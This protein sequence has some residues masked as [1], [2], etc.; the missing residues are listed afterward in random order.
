MS[1]ECD[2]CGLEDPD[3]HCELYELRKRVDALEEILE[4]IIFMVF[5]IKSLVKNPHSIPEKP[6]RT[7]NPRKCK[8]K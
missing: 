3:C 1:S 2:R 6:I 5:E 4:K 7:K 8:N